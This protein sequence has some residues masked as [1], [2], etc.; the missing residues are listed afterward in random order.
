MIEPRAPT[1]P[2]GLPARRTPLWAYLVGLALPF[3]LI[4]VCALAIPGEGARFLGIS[5]RSWCLFAC[6]P[7]TSACLA[8]CWHL[9]GPGAEEEDRDAC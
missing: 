4:V 5:L 7:L 3:T 1:P 8:L 9:G 6:A 2:V